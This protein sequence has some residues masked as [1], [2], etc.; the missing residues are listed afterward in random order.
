MV[1]VQGLFGR[2][3]FPIRYSGILLRPPVF[4]IMCFGEVR[5]L[6]HDT[7]TPFIKLVGVAIYVVSE[8][9]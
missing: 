6:G 4:L 3:K 9:D 8:V 7:I 2:F 5:A 1:C